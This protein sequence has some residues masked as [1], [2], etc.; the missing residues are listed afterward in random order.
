MTEADRA[1][2]QPIRLQTSECFERGEKNREMATGRWN[3]CAA[4]DASAASLGWPSARVF[5][6]AGLLLLVVDDARSATQVRPLLPA[7]PGS[8]VMVTFG[9]A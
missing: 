4:L 2:W 6:R 1:A 8:R 5:V 9:S 7:G 3:G